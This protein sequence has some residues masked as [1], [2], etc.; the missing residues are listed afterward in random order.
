MSLSSF[1]LFFLTVALV[2]CAVMNFVSNLTLTD[3]FATVAFLAAVDGWAQLLVIKAYL[4]GSL[5]V[6][7]SGE[8]NDSGKN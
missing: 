7:K 8:V 1:R 6:T 2:F 4:S 3:V 5:S